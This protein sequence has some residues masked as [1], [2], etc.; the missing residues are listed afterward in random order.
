V[1]GTFDCDCAAVAT[2]RLNAI[3]G[4]PVLIGMSAFRIRFC[5]TL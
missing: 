5:P 1:N 2:S 3:A 4:I